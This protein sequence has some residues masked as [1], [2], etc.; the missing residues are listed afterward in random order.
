MV[1]VALP[2]ALS[3]AARVGARVFAAACAQCHGENAAGRAGK[4]PPLVHRIYEPGH[5]GDASILLAVRNGTRA[6]HW[7]FGNMPPVPGLTDGD[8]KAVTAY[9]RELQRFNGIN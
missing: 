1:Q 4:G 6:H 8:V 7:T 3:P 5:H 9:V 2:E